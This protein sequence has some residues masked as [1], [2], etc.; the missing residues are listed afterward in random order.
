M[1]PR[2]SLVF[3]SPNDPKE[4]HKNDI[5]SFFPNLHVLISNQFLD[6]LLTNSEVEQDKLRRTQPS[7]L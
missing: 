2:D 1:A 3:F 5:M 6:H 4:I 7:S